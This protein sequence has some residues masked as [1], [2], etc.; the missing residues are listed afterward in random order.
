MCRLNSKCALIGPDGICL[1]TRQKAV[2][3][4]HCPFYCA[5]EIPVCGKCGT[6]NL[7]PFLIENANG[8]YVNMCG[9]CQKRRGTCVWCV[10]AN[11]CMLQEYDGPLPKMVMRR[12]QQGNAVIQTQIPN[13]EVIS[14]TCH[15]CECWDGEGCGREF[16]TCGKYEEVKL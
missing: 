3:N 9:N 4:C 12:I 5:T 8:E 1:M 15:F 10:K 13:P 7:D 6:P 2:E 11:K 14:A 16:G